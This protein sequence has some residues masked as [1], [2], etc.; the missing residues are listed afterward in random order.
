[1]IQSKLYELPV[2]AA[3]IIKHSKTENSGIDSGSTQLVEL[4]ALVAIKDQLALQ[5]LYRLTSAHL[6]GILLRILKSNAAAEDA[7]QDIY[8]KIWSKAASYRET[9]GLPMT[10]MTSIA[11][12]HALDI[13]RS[14]HSTRQRDSR[15]AVDNEISSM[16]MITP[17]IEHINS[18]LLSTCLG[19]LEPHVQ[20]LVIDAYCGGYTHE[21]LSD[22]TSNPLG[23]VKS[24]I[25]RALSSLKECIDELS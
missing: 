5:Q 17:E 14:N 25:R 6:F 23:T 24:W 19:R 2:K 18:E 4:L 12:Y 1:M 16:H 15:Y 7:L 9:T 13:I 21:E 8:I 3:V 20:E 10:W 22:R 11:R